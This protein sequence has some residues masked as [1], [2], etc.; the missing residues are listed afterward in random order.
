MPELPEVETIRRQ[1]EKSVVGAVVV[2]VVVR[3]ASCYEGSKEIGEETIEKVERSGKYL[4]IYFRSGRGL[5]VHLK[6]TG[7]I[8]LDVAQYYELPHTR[9]IINMKDG[10]RIFYWDARTFGYIKHV[11][12]VAVEHARQKQKLGPDPWQISE[13][14]FFRLTNKYQ[15][16]IKNLILD[17]S[18]L[19]GVGNIYANDGLWEAGVDPRRAANSL[20]K[21]ESKKLLKGIRYVMERG[22]ATGGASDNSYVNALGKKGS[23]QDEFRVYKRTGMPC[24]RCGTKLLRIVV[25]GRGTWLCRACQK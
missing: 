14:D 13:E 22:L 25:G 23:Y 10:R 15:R 12:N 21:K 3:R 7:R 9:V 24:H 11:E 2:G 20:T 5:V 4:Y 6:M 16:P 8:V 19:A 18:L 17:Q 1:L